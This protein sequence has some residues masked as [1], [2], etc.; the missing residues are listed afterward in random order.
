M[1][2]PRASSSPRARTP[3]ANPASTRSPKPPATGST[4]GSGR[5]TGRRWPSATTAS[6]PPATSS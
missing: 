4:R 1:T 2:G 5:S 6:T 3:P